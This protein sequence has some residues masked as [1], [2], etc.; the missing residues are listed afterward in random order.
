MRSRYVPVQRIINNHQAEKSII[1]E[2]LE[3]IRRI[4]T[5]SDFEHMFFRS[6]G[7]CGVQYPHSHTNKDCFFVSHAI[8]RSIII[9][10]GM[11]GEFFF[12]RQ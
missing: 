1:D 7:H 9:A 8:F 10:L 11:D 2:V 12:W 6:M 3:A 5:K 4:E